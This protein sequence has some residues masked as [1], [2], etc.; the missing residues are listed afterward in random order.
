MR[1]TV[2]I[3]SPAFLSLELTSRCNLRCSYCYHFD[4]SSADCGD[5]PTT[6]WLQFFDELQSLKV[7]TVILSGG[8]PF[9]RPDIFDIIEKCAAS[10]I[11]YTLLTNATLIS[12]EYAKR[13]AAIG[14][15]NVLQVSLD[16]VGAVN[17][18]ARGKG[19]FDAA[20]KGIRNLMDAGLKVYPRLTYSHHN[21]GR[22]EETA[23]FMFKELG[24]KSFG[25]NGATVFSDN[26]KDKQAVELSIREYAAAMREHQLVLKKYPGRIAAMSGP[27]A[28]LRTWSN[29]LKAKR[30]NIQVVCGG[31]HATCTIVYQAMSVRP[32]GAMLACTSFPEHVL[33]YIN[34]DKIADV[35][36]NN[37][38][39][40]ELRA[41]R[42]KPLS[43]YE[44]CRD[45]EYRPWC[46]GGCPAVA[47]QYNDGTRPS[48]GARLCLRKFLEVV[49]DFDFELD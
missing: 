34:K 41:L 43:D 24:V 33:G 1:E 44:Y 21:V 42:R 17:D 32:D 16:G 28:S 22:L 7:F 47:L 46:A 4:S 20:V 10:K 48:C 29:M 39:I 37:E 26:K 19:S 5:L 13:L 25:T 40:N 23:D 6:E 36:R 15:C 31:C 30:D 18:E 35:W 38:F 3:Q 12:A 2:V 11:R 14:R 8:E 27:M 45:C 49:P 9:I